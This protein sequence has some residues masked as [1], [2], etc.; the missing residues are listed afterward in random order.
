M[1]V[2]GKTIALDENTGIDI[3]GDMIE[4]SDWSV[5]K[6]LY[7]DLHNMGHIALAYIHDPDHGHSVG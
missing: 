5:N 3:L 7:G 6:I 1:Q 2:N 4:A